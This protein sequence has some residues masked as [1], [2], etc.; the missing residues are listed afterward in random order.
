MEKTT[1][2]QPPHPRRHP[3]FTGYIGIARADV[4][5]PVGI[6]SRN[7]G[8]AEHDTADSIHRPITVR[9]LTLAT[10]PDDEPLILIDGDL[11]WWRPLELFEEVRD[12]L[13]KEA[14]VPRERLLFALSHTHAGAPLAKIDHD[15]P[16]VELLGP[17]L[18]SVRQ[19]I[20]RCV[21]EAT[22]NP[23]AGLLDWHTGRCQLAAHRDLP[24]PAADQ[25]RIICGYNPDGIADDTLVVGRI[26]D[27]TGR[28]R[29]TLVNYACHPTT[30]AW[31]NTAISPD[32]PG[33]MRETMEEVT[34][35]TAFFLQGV[36]GELSP[37][38]QYVGDPAVADRHGRHLAYSALATLEDMEPPGQ[39]LVFD[40]VKESGAPLAVW[41]HVPAAANAEL[42]AV[43]ATAELPLKKWPTAEEL[44]QQRRA[45]TD[46]TLEERLR[47]KRDI[48]R[49]IGD[50]RSFPLPFSI[51]K[52]G[53][54]VV[55]GCCGE[56]YSVLQQE[57]RKRF[58]DQTLVCMNLVNGSI[59]YLPPAEVYDLNLYQ[60]WQTPFD[61]GCLEA[62]LDAMTKE[63]Q[64]MLTPNQV[65]ADE[66]SDSGD[67]N[68]R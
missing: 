46:R 24:D 35:G 60:V 49:A 21:R 61:R 59:G 27:R 37:R 2:P 11:G 3:S 33:A 19:A 52:I 44:E 18:E 47:R 48:R 38:Y 42:S 23:F 43:E 26:S 12:E 5:P 63:L 20:V 65:G 8:A 56:A 15:L 51:W 57:L 17:W 25:D 64:R 55:A 4:T 14:R 67:A 41:R 10:S 13:L 1:I 22:E 32:F 62:T 7:W 66:N 36:S 29:G 9:V 58:P 45:C 16:G 53:D 40:G 68:V 34:G 30:L 28:I 6:Y 31:E 50:G 54:T 39:Q